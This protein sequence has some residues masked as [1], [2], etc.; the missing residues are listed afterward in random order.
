MA[1]WASHLRQMHIQILIRLRTILQDLI[2]GRLGS[3]SG[4]LELITGRLR[5]LSGGPYVIPDGVDLLT[6]GYQ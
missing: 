6:G 5:L 1:L 3:S 2:S 4:G